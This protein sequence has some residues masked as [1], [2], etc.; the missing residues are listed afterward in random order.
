[1]LRKLLIASLV[2]A[3][4]ACA[5]PDA[6]RRALEAQGFTDIHIDG[7]AYYGCSENDTFATA[8]TATNPRGARVSGV[9]CSSFGPFAK[10]A[11]VRW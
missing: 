3:L 1:M 10:N 9:V 2:Y 6:A 7:P 11:T 4:C 5:D 8:F